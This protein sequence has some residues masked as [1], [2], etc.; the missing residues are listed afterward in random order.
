MI[1]VSVTEKNDVHFP[2]PRITPTGYAGTHVVQNP[3]TSRIFKK[4]R[5]IILTQLPRM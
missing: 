1:A 4:Q 5:P 2:K 3:D